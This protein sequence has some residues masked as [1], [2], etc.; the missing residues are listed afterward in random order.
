MAQSLSDQL[1]NFLTFLE[2][3]ECRRK[4]IPPS[5]ILFPVIWITNRCNLRC[6][7][8]DQWK[9]PEPLI[10]QEL[11]T[12]EWYS[13]IDS[14]ARMHALVIN[15]TGGEPFLRP[16]IFD[17]IRY[18][19]SKNISC[20]ICSNGTQ[21]NRTVIDRL[22][23]SPPDTIS[24]S[25]DS[26]CAEI[27]NELRGVD[28]FDRIVEGVRLLRSNLP[29]VKV[30]INY[31]I[32]RQ[33]FYNLSRMIS[34]AERL[35][36]DQLKFDPIHVNLMH[37]KKPLPS[38]K[39]LLFHEEDLPEL[40]SEIK[41]LM[42]AL[43]NTKL[44]TN[45]YSFVRGITSLYNGRF[46]KLPCHAGYISCAIDAL[47]WVS[48]CDNFEGKENLK[49]KPLEEIWKSSIFQ[50]QRQAVH[51]CSAHCWDSTHAELNIRCSLRGLLEFPQILREFYYYLGSPKDS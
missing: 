36:V 34:F 13:F 9:T 43:G 51:R 30:G 20:H 18:I 22:K 38:F 37:R 3:K 40:H 23:S 50:R 33:N 16:D 26:Y 7:M 1:K 44:L 29:T 12:K 5:S 19:R 45:S 28:C 25:L 6:K 21:F 8:C 10:A 46:D 39:D 4:N 41:K 48:P 24:I 47:G 17:I 42:N 14:V 15:I 32:T 31:V 11:S 49:E 27:H 2:M 35:G